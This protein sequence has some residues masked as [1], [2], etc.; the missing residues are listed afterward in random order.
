MRDIIFDSNVWVAFLNEDDP[1]HPEA[2][3]IFGTHESKIICLPE[4]VA[5][6]TATVI[7]LKKDKKTADLFLEMAL[8]NENIQV[9]YSSKDIFLDTI[10][11]FYRT[12]N[13]KL[14]FVDH[15]LLYFSDKYEVV[16]FDKDLL[17]LIEIT[18]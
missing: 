3:K 18:K 7:M 8:D 4:Y 15:S 10:Q 5:L 6:E 9:L 14:S 16:T 2:V 11:F 13:K 17:K 12:K 1:N